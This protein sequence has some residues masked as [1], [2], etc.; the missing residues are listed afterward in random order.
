MILDNAHLLRE[1]EVPECLLRF[2]AHT[3]AYK[4]V[5]KK[6][7]NAD[8]SEHLSVIYYPVELGTYASNSNAE[9]KAEQL[10]LIG[11]IR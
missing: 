4:A 11:Q 8:Y 7:V 9:L 6:W 5:I 2:V 3:A 1:N 10:R